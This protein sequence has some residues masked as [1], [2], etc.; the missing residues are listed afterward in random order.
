[1]KIADR[2]NRIL[3]ILS[4]VSQNPG[5]LVEELAERV[6]MRPKQLLKELEFMLLIGKPPFRPDDYVDIYVENQRVYVE[7]DQMLNR[8]L[9]FTRPEAMSLLVS[10]QLLDPEVDPDSVESLKT[11]IKEVI[12]KSVD[13]NARVEDRILLERPSL[14]I[15]EHFSRLRQ[16]VEDHEKVRIDYYSL[17]RDKTYERVVHPYLLMKYLGYWYLTAYC[18]LRQD[19]RTFKFERVL[20]VD[21]LNET[22]PQVKDL[23]VDKYKENF[24]GSLGNRQIQVY[25]DEAVAPWIEEQ[26]G[27]SARKQEDGGVVLTLVSET[28]EFPSRLVLSFAPHARPVSPPEFIEKVRSDTRKIAQLYESNLPARVA[29]SE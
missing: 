1:M 12:S 16:A 29:S 3:L 18:E 28:L 10:L 21:S 24:L 27:S 22:F 5:I 19:L 17:T 9:R 13:P 15:S 11:K 4:Y 8:P 7:Y 2:I 23:D 26:W 14:P 20:S 6:G 25:F